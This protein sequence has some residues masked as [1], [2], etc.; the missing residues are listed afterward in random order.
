MTAKYLELTADDL[1]HLCT[2]RIATTG[3]EFSHLEKAALRAFAID[4]AMRF[5]AS[6]DVHDELIQLS[7]ESDPICGVDDAILL[8][9]RASLKMKKKVMSSLFSPFTSR[10]VD[11]VSAYAKE[12]LGRDLTFVECKKMMSWFN[13]CNNKSDKEGRRKLMRY[14]KEKFPERMEEVNAHFRKEDQFWEG[15]GGSL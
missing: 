2:A 10:K 15:V 8:A 14:I 11:R 13:C 1:V 9:P 12:I 7:L 4:L 3:G 5:G 6:R